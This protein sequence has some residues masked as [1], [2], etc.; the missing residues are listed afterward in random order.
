MIT[1]EQFDALVA[2]VE[3][4]EAQL[5][6]Q[7]PKKML[8]PSR[9]E[10]ILFFESLQL[11]SSDGEWFFDKCEGNGWRAGG[12]PIKNWQATVRAWMKAK[13]LPSQKFN[14]NGAHHR[15]AAEDNGQAW[16]RAQA[17]QQAKLGRAAP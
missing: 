8:A 2:R 7:G 11:P 9:G 5:K 3:A 17:E 12:A 4:L 14:G 6:R 13:Y 1:Q 16:K 15:H 10:V